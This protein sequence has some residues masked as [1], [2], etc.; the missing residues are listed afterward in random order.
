[1]SPR[2][3]VGLT[4]AVLGTMIGA[5]VDVAVLKPPPL[6][7][8]NASASAPIGLY[9]LHFDRPPAV[10][11]LAVV[12]PPPALAAFMAER[13]YLPVGVPLLKRVAVLPGARVC[14]FGDVV[15]IAGIAIAAARPADSQHRPLPVWRGCRIVGRGEVFLLNFVSD[16]FDGRYFG[17]LPASGVIGRATPLLTRNHPHASLRW[18]GFDGDMADGATDAEPVLG[19]FVAPVAVPAEA[20][21]PPILP[22]FHPQPKG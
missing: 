19:P 8:W 6:L 12:T 5:W 7:I 13:R 14:R 9:R 4:G 15:T 17:A 21:A 11:E 16:S 22:A 2:F 10:G 18:H 1:M 20:S 3:Y